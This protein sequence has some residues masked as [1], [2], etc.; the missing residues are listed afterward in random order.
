MRDSV[1]INLTKEN[2][3]SVVLKSKLPVLVDFW[4]AWCT[5]CQRLIPI[6]EDLSK[7]LEGKAVICKIDVEEEEEL[8]DFYEI[9]SIPTLAV[10]KDKEIVDAMIGVQSKDTLKKLL[11]L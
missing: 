6:L 4:A 10:F 2:F 8:A 7:E 5:P 3:E 1:V 9:L 11:K